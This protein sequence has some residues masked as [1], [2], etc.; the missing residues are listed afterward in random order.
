MNEIILTGNT[1]LGTTPLGRKTAA[2]IR[3]A[4]NQIKDEKQIAIRVAEVDR[5]ELAT[6]AGFKNTAAWASEFLGFSKSKVSRYTSITARFKWV[7]VTDEQGR[8][9][10]DIF[11]LSQMQEM[12]KANDEQL[13]HI[14]PDMTV[15]DI[16]EYLSFVTVPADESETEDATPDEP[17]T[18]DADESE[19]EDA[20]PDTT[21][22]PVKE[23]D[24]I[25]VALSY[26][27]QF[28][29]AND[30]SPVMFARVGDK[31]RVVCDASVKATI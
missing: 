9:Y 10:W 15:K 22:P 27:K 3:L 24:D 2:I 13:Q 18:G 16:R 7:K 31:F 4:N 29:L 12:L 6:A 23:F 20:T 28:A 5:D 17:E 21:T 8:D 30:G 25:T 26:I 14:T 1:K 19:T 11:T